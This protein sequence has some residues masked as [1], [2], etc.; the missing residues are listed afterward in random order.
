MISTFFLL[1]NK[2]ASVRI[3]YRGGIEMKKSL[4][5]KF[6]G[7]IALVLCLPIIVQAK[8]SNDFYVKASDNIKINKNI[9]GS[10]LIAG[11]NIETEGKIEG[12]GFIFGNNVKINNDSE[13][14]ITAANNI[15]VV[16][17]VE[18]DVFIA[19]NIVNITSDVNIG[20]DLIIAA[21]EVNVSGKI[22]R[23]VKIYAATINF[24]GAIIE[25]NVLADASEINVDEETT[26]KGTLEYNE[27]AQ[28]QID[29][30]QIDQKAT[31]QNE[32]ETNFGDVV[33][34]KL[35]S[36]VST[37]IV[38]LVLAL[39]FAKVV[40]TKVKNLVSSTNDVWKKF[41]KGLLYLLLIPIIIVLLFCTAVGS[42]LALILLAL[43]IIFIY[44]SKIV[45]GYMLGTLILNKLLKKENNVLLS[46]FIGILLLSLI[47][48]IPYLGSF[49]SVF[50]LLFGLGIIADLFKSIITK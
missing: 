39:L 24:E 6:I 8:S 42:A 13:Y 25:G 2:I 43:Y 1:T 41:M 50:S 38:F 17:N 9:V 30:K 35:I 11:N 47:Y 10:S 23:N 20:R 12:I 7:L 14:L 40:D 37:L 15:D 18:K 16:K 22:G 31:Y 45:S 46:G 19:A 44:I 5:K 28:V 26:I 36:L 49:V 34:D 32:T 27:N 29:S 3:I 21:N 4:T 48:L 33:V